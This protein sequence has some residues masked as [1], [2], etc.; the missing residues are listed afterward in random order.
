MAKN[1]KAAETFILEYIEKM[2]PGSPNK[3]LYEDYFKSM[4]DEQFDAYMADLE[5]GAKFLVM[6]SPNFTTPSLSVERNLAIAKELNHDFFQHIWFGERE[7]TPAYLS[8]IKY[9]VV[10]LPLRRA[11]QL[12]TKK[13]S[14]PDDNKVIDN[15]TGQATGDS[16][17]ARV[18]YSE[19]QILASMGMDECA[20]E[21]F[22]YR[23]GDLKGFNA[24]NAMIGRFGSANQKTL[25][26][27]A[28]GVE[29]TRTLRT[30]LTSAHL[31]NNL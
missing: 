3:G 30:F 28:S 11:S 29:S 31:K 24:L 16:G 23:G 20:T 13:I 22:K 15:T 18:S 26:N 6:T 27:Y 17:R 12:L 4:S 8:P 7:G 5:S 1:R 10:D 14:I 21:L 2:L 9:L 25:G 19:L